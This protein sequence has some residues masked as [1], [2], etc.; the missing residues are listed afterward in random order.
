MEEVKKNAR[1][2]AVRRGDGLGGGGSSAAHIR[3]ICRA[4]M[5]Y[6]A[7]GKIAA[8]KQ[9]AAVAGHART[10]SQLSARHLPGIGLPARLALTDCREV[11]ML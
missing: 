10:G 3:S 8:D 4:A 11:G 2:P 9:E 5:T 6:V 7:A 1:R